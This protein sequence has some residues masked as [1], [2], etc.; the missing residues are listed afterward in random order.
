MRSLLDSPVL[1]MLVAL[2][3]QIAC[4]YAGGAI[5][6]RLH[7]LPEDQRASFGI[8][9]SAALGL[10]ALL[11]GFSFSMAVSR[12]DLRKSLEAEEA[13]AIGTEYVRSDLLASDAAA[14]MRDKLQAYLERRMS[15]YT[16]S[17]GESL[18][19]IARDEQSL[20]AELWSLVVRAAKAE[21]TPTAAL[22]VAGLNDVLNAKG[23]TE[24]AWANRVPLAAWALM[25]L[26][27]I[28]CCVALGYGQKQADVLLLLTVPVT[29]SIS[30]LLVADIDSPRGG[31]IH[32]TPHNL[33]ALATS[34]G[35]P[36]APQVRR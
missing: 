13:N 26:V 25:M 6:S 33:L 31:I 12:Y 23:Y 17:D 28:A 32:V 29:V 35:A 30:F 4:L 15:F 18:A 19:Q 16:T 21:P 22:A 5:R 3:V 14:A 11:I 24:A 7:A 8:V 36:A 34:L 1:I 10:L 20:Q 9:Q 27:A 2:V